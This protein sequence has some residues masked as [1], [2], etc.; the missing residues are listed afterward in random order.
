MIKLTIYI[1]KYDDFNLCMGDNDAVGDHFQGLA[2]WI[3]AA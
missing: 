1:T 3:F 2:C